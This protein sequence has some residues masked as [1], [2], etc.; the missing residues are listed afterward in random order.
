MTS[1]AWGGVEKL[2][3]YIL[4]PALLISSL[5]KQ[6]INGIPWQ[7]IMIVVVSVLLIATTLLI[8]ARPL[9]TENNALF[10]SI[11]QGSIRFNTYIAFAVAHTLYGDQGLEISAVVAGFMIV[12]V[13]LL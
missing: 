12:L 1:E 10:T 8:I 9:L 4:F 7:S 2:T 3:Y 11:F 5:G 6:S 13:N